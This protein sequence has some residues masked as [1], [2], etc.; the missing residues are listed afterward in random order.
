MVYL[1]LLLL[2][3]ALGWFWL[4][5]LRAREL[6]TAICHAAC[7]QR[8]VQFLDQTVALCRIGI[9]WLP[10]GLRLRRVYRFDFSQEGVGRHT[11]SITMLGTVFQKLEMDGW[12]G[13]VAKGQEAR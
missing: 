6:A 8:E 4:D 1:G 10:E 13:G 12:N 3:V 9:R 5:S 7:K 11:G 2:L